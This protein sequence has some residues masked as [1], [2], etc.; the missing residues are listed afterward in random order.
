ML[1]W[2]NKNIWLGIYCLNSEIFHFK[3][4]PCMRSQYGMSFIQLH[5]YYSFT[6][7]IELIFKDS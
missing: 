1:F 4:V 2:L 3:K 6:I 5:E 7:F